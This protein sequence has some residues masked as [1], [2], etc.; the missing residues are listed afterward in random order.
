MS[1]R[2][3]KSKRSA[4]GEW[5]NLTAKEIKA[6]RQNGCTAADWRAVRVAPGFRPETVAHCRFSG[7]VRLGTFDKPVVCGGISLPSGVYDSHLHDVSVADNALVQR[8]ALIANYDIGVGACVWDC[9]EVAVEGE[10]SFGNGISI[11]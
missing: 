5:R 10:T 7:E 1:P 3:A 2:A 4:K 6:L 9:G 8:V 11:E